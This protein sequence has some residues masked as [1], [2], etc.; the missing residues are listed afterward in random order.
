[1]FDVLGVRAALG[2]AFVPGEDDWARRHVVLL[3][4]G[5]WK[6]AFAGD[7][8]VVGRRVRIDGEPRE[9]AGVMPPGAWFSATLV[10]LWLPLAF[11]PGDP[12]N[13]RNSHYLSVVARLR[14]EAT[15]SRARATM[16]A[17][18]AQLAREHPQND[19][20]GAAVAPLREAVLGEVRPS[21]LLM[22]GAVGLV[23]LTACANLANLLLARSSGRAREL[24]VR[25]TLGASRRRL[26]RQLLTESLLLSAA[27]GGLGLLF[28]SWANDLALLALPGLP[29]LHETGLALDRGMLAFTAGLSMLTAAVFGMGP[30]LHG[31]SA[32]AA[33]TL[34]EGGRGGTARRA[35]RARSALVVSEMALAT[36]LLAGAGLLIRSFRLL[37]DVDPGVRRGELL[38][39]RIA[40]PRA[41]ALD[42]AFLRSF[43]ERVIA[44]TEALP[45][46][47]AAGVS[48]HRP[49]GGGGM[50]RQFGVEGDPPPRSLADVPSVSARQESAR[51][52]QALG[53]S[54]LRGRLFGEQ[55]RENAERVCVIN[56]AL[57]DR[58]F[59]GRD[60]LGR[61]ILL[62]APEAVLTPERRPPGGRWAR[63]TIVGVVRDVRYQGLAAAPEAVAYVPYRQRTAVMPWAPGYL[64]VRASGDAA[65]LAPAIRRIVAEADPDYAVGEAMTLEEL[66]AAAVGP[67]RVNAAVM[68]AFGASALL[69]A[70]LGIYGVLSYAVGQ[71]RREFGI[72][73]A[74]G[75]RAGDVVRLVATQAG[76]LAGAGLVAGL[77]GAAAA[78]GALNRLLYGVGPADPVTLAAVCGVLVS[79]A[80]VASYVPARRAA[81]V[82]PAAALRA[83]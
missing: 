41:R 29:R 76:R 68:T 27:G 32:P 7:P 53:V 34:G 54:L 44:R 17:V 51:S 49:L 19:G 59:A 21:L 14:P 48:S 26:V 25:A 45:G 46:V 24:A 9:I 12:T 33:E 13:D 73:M 22:T 11:P 55:D 64:I 47:T 61:Q 6:R 75:A 28:A 38:T 80:F 35:T 5:L 69:L 70:L 71:R 42:D 82:D 8:A 57:A 3:S 58:H 81:R 40:L 78:A 30:A 10:D 62:E 20:L 31:A 74:L 37:Q 36:M 65:S 23:L 66:V 60:P 67:T 39:L 63:W 2:R 77:L 15:L 18:A 4:H 50:S 79:T 83:D 1:M 16:D 72:R 43:F 52:L 56:Q